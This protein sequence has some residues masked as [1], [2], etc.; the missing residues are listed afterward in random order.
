VMYDEDTEA[1]DECDAVA[2]DQRLSLLSEFVDLEAKHMHLDREQ[3]KLAEQSHKVQA[4]MREIRGRLG[5]LL[6]FDDP[7]AAAKAGR[8]RERLDDMRA[9]R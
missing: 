6:G 7:M 4:R 3:K 5:E 8:V 9:E 1:R 2:I